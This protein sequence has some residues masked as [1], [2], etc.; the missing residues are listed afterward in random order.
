MTGA[1][2][3]GVVQADLTLRPEPVISGE[4]VADIIGHMAGLP[5]NANV[6]ACTVLATAMPFTGRG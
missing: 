3:H 6:Q 5:L 1:F 4:V 2:T